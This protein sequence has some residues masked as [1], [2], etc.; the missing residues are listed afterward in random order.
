MKHSYR[1]LGYAKG[2][3][4]TPLGPTLN[5]FMYSCP[6]GVSTDWTALNMPFPFFFTQYVKFTPT[7]FQTF[8]RVKLRPS[9]AVFCTILLGVQQAGC[10]AMPP[11]HI[12]FYGVALF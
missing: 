9:S 2:K 3:G 5:I 12:Q 11:L 7:R 8:P 10:V 4:G 6:L 1:N